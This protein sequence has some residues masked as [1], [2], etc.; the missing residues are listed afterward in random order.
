[1]FNEKRMQMCKSSGK[2]QL[3]ISGSPKIKVTAG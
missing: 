3:T 1:M 2:Y